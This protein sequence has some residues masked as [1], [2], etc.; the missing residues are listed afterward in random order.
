MYRF[1]MMKRLMALLVSASFLGTY[2]LPSLAGIVTTEQ[3]LQQASSGVDRAALLSAL[4]RDE[5]RQQLVARGVDPDAARQR[6]A[7]LSDAQVNT[8]GQRI[9]ELPA[10]AGVLELL[11]A[12]VLV[13]VI[14]DVVG[15][16]NI[17]SFIHPPSGR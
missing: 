3:L 6:I 12:V 14:L 16:T 2:P 5:V 10:G 13:L 9:D 8:L 7:A 1:C 17:F 15:V 11:I 4:D